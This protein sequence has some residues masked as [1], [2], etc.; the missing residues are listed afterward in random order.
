MR[1][2]QAL[3]PGA[4]AL[5]LL[6]FAEGILMARTLAAKRREPVDADRELT[7]LGAGNVAAG[8]VSG[9]PVGAS[10]SRSVTAD[11]AGAQT[12][13]AQWIAAR[14]SLLFVLFLAPCARARCRAWRCRR[15]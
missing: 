8:L 12:Q 11:A 9:F 2:L 13:L 7:A 14:C 1:D 5:A 4:L 6:V 15:S 10:T 3:A